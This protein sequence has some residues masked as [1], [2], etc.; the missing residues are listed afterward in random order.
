MA[1]GGR[2]AYAGR[3]RVVHRFVLPSDIGRIAKK[4]ILPWSWGLTLG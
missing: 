4:H 3:V 2:G 1:A